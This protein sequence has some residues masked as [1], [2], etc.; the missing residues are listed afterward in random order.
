MWIIAIESG[1]ERAYINGH[2]TQDPEIAGSPTAQTID[3]KRR[4]ITHEGA[5]WT[6]EVNIDA[7]NVGTIIT[8]RCTKT[9]ATI[10]QADAF[11]ADLT[12][13][14][15][16][17]GLVLLSDK[18]DRIFAKRTSTY[19]VAMLKVE[20]QVGCAVTIGYTVRAGQLFS[21]TDEDFNYRETDDGMGRTTDDDTNRLTDE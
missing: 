1:G 12:G 10:H 4:Q 19:A 3:H 18:G 16:E 20:S 2:P 17:G 14:I 21:A 9:F 15:F 11:A 7:G 6:E 8:G 13:M 5:G